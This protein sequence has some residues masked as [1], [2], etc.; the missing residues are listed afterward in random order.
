MDYKTLAANVKADSFKMAALPRQIRDSALNAII[1]DLTA[2]K[3]AIF[4]ANAKDLEKAAADALPAPI[5]N[6]LKF[7]EHK[8]NDCI[9]GIK[10]L[11]AMEDPLFQ[12]LLKRQLDEG[13]TLIK[14]TCPIGVI[15]VIFESRPDALVQISSLC[16]KSGNCAI[17]KG[18]SEA[19]NTNRIL[20][21]II[22]KAGTTAGLP[23]SFALLIEDRAGIDELLKCHES[24]D[25]IIPRGSNQFVSYIMANSKIPVMGH[26]DGVCHVYV[27]KDADLE[28]AVPIVIDS[29]TQYVAACNAAETLLV[30][31]SIASQ[32]L[33]RLAEAS[34]ASI[35]Y[36][37][38]ET[39]CSLIGCKAADDQDFE[40]EYLDYILSIKVVDNADEAIDHINRYGSHHTDCI[41]TE[42]S[43]T[44]ARFMANVDSAGVYQNCSTRFA[45]GFR[46]GFGAEVGISTGKLHAR[47]PVGLDGL[48]TYKYK[49]FGSGQI[50]SDYAGG[51]RSFHF[52]DLK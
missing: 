18:G 44:A 6:R 8:L 16:I 42:N 40:T 34:G 19:G 22:Y 33:P 35:E 50:V 41:V 51:V 25:L 2:N 21:D 36:R 26:A 45:D 28:K 9:S 31:R 14:T 29:K 47:G 30:N 39:V 12:E 5:Q 3:E 11:I 27:D 13:L 37:G 10:D 23:Q 1:D 4:A 49:L 52:K 32:F 15:G 20:F 17:L 24:V 43:D 46:Y 48:V 38:D 7:D